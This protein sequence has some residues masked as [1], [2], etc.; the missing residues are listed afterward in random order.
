M[1]IKEIAVAASVGVISIIEVLWHW[2]IAVSHSR[3]AYTMLLV[4]TSRDT[5]S[6]KGGYPWVDSIIPAVLLGLMVGVLGRG[7]PY[8]KVCW[9]VLLATVDIVVLQ[10]IYP[11]FF[12]KDVLWWVSSGKLDIASLIFSFVE[13]III[14]SFF[15]LAGRFGLQ[16]THQ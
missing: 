10:Q 3:L 6:G 7:W 2:F 12:K 11:L 15:T 4:Y 5:K 8:R 1:R 14:V 13:A 16:K 9:F